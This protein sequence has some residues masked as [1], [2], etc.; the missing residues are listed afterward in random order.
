MSAEDTEI[1]VKEELRTLK[2]IKVSDVKATNTLFNHLMGD[3]V[4]PRKIFIEKH[5]AEARFI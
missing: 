3:S 1:L 2:Q 5:S 4:A